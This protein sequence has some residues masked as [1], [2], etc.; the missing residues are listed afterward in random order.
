MDFKGKILSRK[1]VEYDDI[2]FTPDVRDIGNIIAEEVGKP[3]NLLETLSDRIVR[4]VYS[5]FGTFLAIKVRV[6]KLNPGIFGADSWSASASL[7]W[8]N[9]NDGF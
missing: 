4:A 9:D 3:C 5:S 2:G 1:A 7:N 6:A 8:D